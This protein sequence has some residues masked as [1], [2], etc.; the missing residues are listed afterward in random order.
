MLKTIFLN[1]TSSN[2]EF[3]SVFTEEFNNDINL[4]IKNKFRI[5]RSKIIFFAETNL[6]IFYVL[7]GG[8]VEGRLEEIKKQINTFFD[9]ESWILIY[10]LFSERKIKTLTS[11]N[12]G[13]IAQSLLQIEQENIFTQNIQKGLHYYIQKVFF[14]LEEFSEN[15][16]ST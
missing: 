12:M 8:N 14:L 7:K 6:E 10:F 13:Y 15:P 2:K 9:S 1:F 16:F 11:K 4:V 5:N 3:R